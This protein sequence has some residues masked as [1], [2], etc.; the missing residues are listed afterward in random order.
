[1]WT[2]D[3]ELALGQQQ[4]C[5]LS[6]LRAAKTQVDPR[7]CL[8]TQPASKDRAGQ[9]GTARRPILCAGGVQRD[10]VRFAASSPAPLGS[11]REALKLFPADVAKANLY[12]GMNLYFTFFAQHVHKNENIYNII[13]INNF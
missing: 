10:K 4:R 1:M 13:N 6:G 7:W 12:I 3:V 8:L 9:L 5:S 2:Q 11:R